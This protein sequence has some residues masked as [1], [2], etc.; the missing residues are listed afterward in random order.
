MY[1]VV[2]IN[3]NKLL[4][5]EDKFR[6]IRLSKERF[7]ISNGKYYNINLIFKVEKVED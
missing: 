2:F 7:F 5:S 1:Q 4:I 6:D 3:G